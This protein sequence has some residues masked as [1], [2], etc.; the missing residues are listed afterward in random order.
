MT[1]PAALREALVSAIADSERFSIRATVAGAFVA[2]APSSR[3]CLLIPTR[4]GTGRPVGRVSGSL[5]VTFPP[6]VLFDVNARQWEAPCAVV[7]C[8]D[9]GLLSAFC[10]LC[11]DVAER[12]TV[13]GRSPSPADV[14]AALAD[15]ERLLRS[16]RRLSD[17]EE[18]GLWG[19]LALLERMPDIDA[20]IRSWR[21][22][23]GETVDFLGGGIGLE[24]KTSKL[25]LQHHVS[26][27]QAQRPLGD[28]P[29]YLV[30][31]WSGVD[32][33]AGRTVN[34][35]ADV[36]GGRTTE[37]I[38]LERAL[39]A[40]GYS[41]IDA[42]LYTTRFVLLEPAHWF[43]ELDIPRIRQIDTGIMHVRYVVQLDALRALD[44]A[45][46]QALERQ[47]TRPS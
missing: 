27:A 9:E 42:S 39:L 31:Q 32:A 13:A 21:G 7:E 34:D 12:L 30:S 22:P 19:E 6:S 10:A 28:V 14:A 5:S 29:V 20:A 45:D 37:T 1:T 11:V 33:Q 23:F 47:F 18:M 38:A 26:L 35:L 46:V 25:R 15:W 3:A 8:L 40:A 2:R 16:R 41:R 44:D 17:T 4:A 36:I 43:A 24:C